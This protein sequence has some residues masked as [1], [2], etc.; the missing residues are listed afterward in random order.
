MPRQQAGIARA[1]T[2]GGCGWPR[3]GTASSTS[4][5]G[6]T[7][8]RYNSQ[9]LSQD[10]PNVKRSPYHDAYKG[11]TIRPRAIAA[12]EAG[13]VYVGGVAACCIKN[14]QGGGLQLNGQPL[15]DYAGEDAWVL[16][17]SPDFTADL[18][19][20]VWNR[21]GKGEVRGLAAGG[22]TAAL[23]ARAKGSFHTHQALQEVGHSGANADNS[24]G[25]ASV[26]PGWRPAP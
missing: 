5:G 17:T 11:N 10:A 7:I 1:P 18:L 6:N 15:P 19:W 12:D 9:N 8:Y 3:G 21:G 4:P 14:R 26:W 25:Y 16:V 13:R 2:P 24:N 22:G 23:A 20:M